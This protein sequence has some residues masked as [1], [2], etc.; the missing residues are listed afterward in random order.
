MPAAVT[1]DLPEDVGLAIEVLGS[2]V[3]YAT[4]R[5]LLIDGAA[6]RRDLADRLGVSTSLLPALMRRLKELGVIS[7]SP[8]RSDPGRLRTALQPEWRPCASAR[9]LI[10]RGH[11]S[12]SAR[13]A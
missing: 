5:S 6:A 4:V 7:P 11:S 8:A 10:L 9:E 3:R 13:M 1:P 12:R 2:K